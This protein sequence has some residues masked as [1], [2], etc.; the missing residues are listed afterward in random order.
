MPSRIFLC[1]NERGKAGITVRNSGKGKLQAPVYDTVPPTAAITGYVIGFRNVK[2][3]RWSS[4]SSMFV[5]VYSDCIRRFFSNR[6]HWLRHH[7]LNQKSFES[8]WNSFYYP[9]QTRLVFTC[10]LHRYVAFTILLVSRLQALVY[11]ILPSTSAVFSYSIGSRK[12]SVNEQFF[13]G[14]R[15]VISL[16]QTTEIKQGVSFIDANKVYTSTNTTTIV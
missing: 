3:I 5:A 13:V 10:V 16:L 8:R 7:K 1:L 2:V 9:E 4:D 12:L 11:D 14:A 6:P 15:T